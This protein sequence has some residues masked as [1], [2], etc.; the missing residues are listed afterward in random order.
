[1]RRQRIYIDS[2]VIGGC[3]DREFKEDS[4]SLI[5]MAE[6]GEIVLLVSDLL[7]RELET[8]PETVRQILRDIPGDAIETI[9]TTDDALFLAGQ[10]L[11][12][13]V[14]GTASEDDALHV[15]LATAHTADIIV[16]WNFKHIVHVQKIRGFNAINLRH[17]FHAIEI[18]TP[19]EVVPS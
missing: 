4:C 15:A 9:S 7:L 18:R 13:G 14:L 10:Y 8:A 3:G 6:R 19:K 12:E 17:G 5:A 2:S 16:S 1:M 11:D